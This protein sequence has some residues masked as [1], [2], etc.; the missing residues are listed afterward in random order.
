MNNL[1]IPNQ[2][3]IMKKDLDRGSQYHCLVVS[4]L[5]INGANDTLLRA[6]F[7]LQFFY[8]HAEDNANN[9]LG[10]FGTKESFANTNRSFIFTSN[11]SKQ[12]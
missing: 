2:C 1:S 8:L 12:I 11:K 9:V 3:L 10:L 6:K 4:K 7:L 5:S